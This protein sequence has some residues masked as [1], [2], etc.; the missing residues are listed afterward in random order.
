M[1]A[2]PTRTIEIVEAFRETGIQPSR[3]QFFAGWTRAG[4]ACGCALFAVARLRGIDCMDATD[5]ASIF[6]G[7]SV[8]SLIYGWD[9]PANKPHMAWGW[10]TKLDERDLTQL[11]GARSWWA[12]VAAGLVPRTHEIAFS[13]L[14]Q[15]PRWWNEEAA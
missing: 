2:L 6:T 8:A 3:A 14:S 1:I 13:D 4:A 12:C 11:F 9:N 10:K 15:A 7:G 5:A